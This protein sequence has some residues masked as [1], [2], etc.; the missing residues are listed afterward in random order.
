M[1]SGV[2]APL[3]TVTRLT[4]TFARGVTVVGRF[5]CRHPRWLVGFAVIALCCGVL[6]AFNSNTREARALRRIEQLRG[7]SQRPRALGRRFWTV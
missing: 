1:T 5:L 3:S 6:H 4:P 2:G 7:A